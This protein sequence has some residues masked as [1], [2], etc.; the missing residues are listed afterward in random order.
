M[1]LLN[2]SDLMK[3][4]KWKIENV[5]LWKSDLKTKVLAGLNGAAPSENLLRRHELRRHEL[6]RHDCVA[7][8]LGTR[9][10]PF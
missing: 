1:D 4:K 3:I 10:S 2:S 7:A 9:V 8:A 6:G 5:V